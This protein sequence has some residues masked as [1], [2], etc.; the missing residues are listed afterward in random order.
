MPV[1]HRQDQNR[2]LRPPGQRGVREG[3][4]DPARG[5]AHGDAR[6][7][8]G[9]DGAGRDERQNEQV[10]LDGREDDT[11]GLSTLVTL[12]ADEVEI[13]FESNTIERKECGNGKIL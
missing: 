4:Q 13:D 7:A 11:G 1:V 12:P 9:V 8:E 3:G 10:H 2:A 6:R 5:D